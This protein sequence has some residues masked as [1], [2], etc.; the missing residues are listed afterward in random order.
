MGGRAGGTAADGRRNL[1]SF[2][3]NLKAWA[4]TLPNINT[5][6][7]LLM[8]LGNTNADSRGHAVFERSARGSNHDRGIDVC[9]SK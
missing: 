3:S 1:T 9:P 6:T 7:F 8:T 5:N 2:V 4:I